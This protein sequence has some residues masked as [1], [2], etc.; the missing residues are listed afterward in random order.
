MPAPP[1][2]DLPLELERLR[3]L[4]RTLARADADDL[5][6][7]AAAAAMAHPPATD[8]PIG[9]WLA[10]VLR[11]RWRMDRR[12]AARR[13]AREDTT[14]LPEAATPADVL[15]DRARTVER[16]AAALVEL[17][18]PF[19]ETIM[20]RFFDDQRAADIARATGVP[21]GTVRW[22]IKVGL[23]RLR[24]ALDRT[25]P[26]AQ[27]QRAIA[28]WAAPF[29]LAAG[30][31][32]KSKSATVIILAVVLLL[33][34]GVAWWAR[35]GRDRATRPDVAG[36]ASPG[37]AGPRAGA[38]TA[39][40][41]PTDPVVDLAATEDALPG[42]RRAA[43]RAVA[44]AD[45]GVRGRVIN[46]STGDGVADAELTFAR[47]GGAVITARTDA[48]GRFALAATDGAY[49]LATAEATG[50]LPFA[51]E[52]QHSAVRLT[53]RP[54]E[55][56]EGVTI[57]LF[58]A[59]DYTG[60]VVD[61]GGAPVA[62]ATVRML[63]SPTGEQTLTALPTAWTTDAKGEFGFHAGDGAI[64]EARR[65][66][67]VGRGMLDGN[68]ALTH[69]MTIQLG[70]GRPADATLAGIVVDQDGTPL[71]GVQVRAEP[72]GP[73]R[74]EDI[75]PMAFATSDDQGRFVLRD[76]DRG[77]YDLI[78]R[79]DGFAPSTK[80]GVEPA[81]EVRLV[82]EPGASLAGQVRT[83][84]GD[85]VP[86]FTLLAFQVRG[87]ARE[88]I[89]ARSVIDGE[90]RFREQVP[91]G[92]YELIVSAPGWAPAGPQAARTG[93]E[94]IVRLAAGAI[95]RGS[96]VSRDTHEP[97]PYARVMREARGGG[98]TAQPANAGTVTRLDGT[99]ELT[100]VPPGP[101]ALMI[102]AGGHHPRIEAGMI[103]VEGG[104]LGPLAVALAPVGPDETP[105]LEVVGI[106]VKLAGD[107]DALRVDAVIEGGGAAAAGL[108]VGDRIV[109]VDGAAVP[110]IGLDG[111]I[112]RIRG[113]AGTRVRLRLVRVGAPAPVD[114]DVERRPLKS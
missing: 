74:P 29:T 61:S 60:H 2:V 38:V 31:T 108:V 113:T 50:F 99:F 9:P 90:G 24:A 23:E 44:D 101:V 36:V 21:A 28:P 30:A 66:A 42:Q 35:F 5:I 58:P 14:A 111:A 41:G 51:P 114:L 69:H 59:V 96:V 65:G 3:A 10:T 7:D 94:I 18:D 73:G 83:T 16:L 92:D 46:W 12:G 39:A 4:A 78:A 102:A 76:L 8:R 109:A 37:K 91:E 70:D 63:G 11:N 89:A 1:A 80:R 54:R 57:F 15:L 72:G 105:H 93:D 33:A 32:V 27:W 19:R 62:G 100:G 86:A 49:T 55:Q 75:R 98:T 53:T 56:V 40:R 82:L 104:V 77:V 52:W 22:R 43:V 87:V 64:F 79:R 6:Q 110:A 112:A 47:A 88:L 25:E 103:A 84:T 71:D 68:V 67:Q 13:V 97:L 45:A 106:G 20:R 48:A 17:E 107:G 95:V 34:G 85:P 26:R 81:V